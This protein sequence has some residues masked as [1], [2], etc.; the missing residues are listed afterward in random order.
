M[1]LSKKDRVILIHQHQILQKLVPEEAAEHEKAIEILRYGYELL[2]DEI[3]QN[4]FEEEI[5]SKDDCLEVWETL[6]MFDSIDRTIQHLGL[7]H[8]PDR[9]TMFFGYDG[10]NEGGFLGFAEFTVTKDNR[11][12]YLPMEREN[13]FNSHMPARSVYQ[14]MLETWKQ[15]PS[16]ARFPM[17]AKQL[18]SVLNAAVHPENR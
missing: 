14:R 15:V 1:Q 17:T 12:T 8:A 16:G 3:Y 10:N 11:F 5:L 2:Y 7:D 13:Y 4:V 9:T 18:E 6:S